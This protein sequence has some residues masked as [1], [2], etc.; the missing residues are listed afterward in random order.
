MNI[1]FKRFFAYLIDML[2]IF[3]I[4]CLIKQFLPVNKYEIELNNLNEVYFE[5]KIEINEYFNE[6]QTITHNIDKTN[7]GINIINTI[8]IVVSFVIIPFISK[9]QT[10]GQKLLKIKIVK[11]DIKLEDYVGR[12]VI[13]N[14]LGYMF[15]MFIILYLTNDNIY[16]ILINLLGF[17]QIL[18][19][20]INCFMV[21]YNMHKCAIAVSFMKPR[22]LGIKSE[23]LQNKN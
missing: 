17:F 15:F 16:F 7:L 3:I 20:I 21:L 2:I 18:V 1:A 12:A 23:K 11:D 6:V 13:I 5:Q 8:L 4:I 9:G 19:V 14:G 10:I 22:I